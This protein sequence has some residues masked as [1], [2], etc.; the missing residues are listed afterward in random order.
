MTAAEVSSCAGTLVA[1]G[2]APSTAT[3]TLATLRSILAFTVADA[4]VQHNVA[5]AEPASKPARPGTYLTRPSG[6]LEV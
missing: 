5:V 1:R 2:L 3:R 4:R 6:P